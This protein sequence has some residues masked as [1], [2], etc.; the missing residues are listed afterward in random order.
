MAANMFDDLVLKAKDFA[1]AAGKKTA[2]LYE[3]SRYKYECI[4]LNGELRGLYEQLGSSVYSMEKGG[5]R[6]EELIEA[7][8]EEI[9]ENLDRLKA[10]NALIA[11]KKN[12][13]ICPVCGAKNAVDNSYCAKC[14]SKMREEFRSASV[15]PPEASDDDEASA[16]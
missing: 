1:D 3:I 7:L 16:E 12:L 4:K 2:D 9:D 10:I 11:D 14:G 5:Y 8:C 13:A 6:N 15:T